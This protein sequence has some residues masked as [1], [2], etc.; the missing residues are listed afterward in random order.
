MMKYPNNPESG[1]EV[2]I[3]RYAGGHKTPKKQKSPVPL[4]LQ[5]RTGMRTMIPRRRGLSYKTQQIRKFMNEPSSPITG[6]T[7][8]DFVAFTKNG[9]R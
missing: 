7:F 9:G 3:C 6:M 5:P 4:E 2:D 8:A 1:A